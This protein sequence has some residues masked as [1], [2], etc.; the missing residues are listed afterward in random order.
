MEEPGEGGAHRAHRLCP[1]EMI[2]MPSSRVG[3]TH[4]AR[5]SL[6]GEQFRD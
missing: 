2:T 5:R 1:G 3:G 6:G 4:R